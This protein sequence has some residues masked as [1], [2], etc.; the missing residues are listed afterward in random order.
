MHLLISIFCAFFI[1]SSLPAITAL[2]KS[3][4]PKI[5]NKIADQKSIKEKQESGYNLL[6]E[7]KKHVLTSVKN[8]SIQ[9]KLALITENVKKIL[10]KY[11]DNTLVIR[12][13]QQLTEYIDAAIK[14]EIIAV[15]TETNNSLVPITCKLMGPC[16]YTPG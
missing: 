2:P 10:G 11:A 14:N 16:I 7:Y 13:R 3:K 4:V 6:N 9:E 5:I 12:T 15:D 8:F 1:S